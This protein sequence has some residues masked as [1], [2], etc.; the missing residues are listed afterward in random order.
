MVATDQCS[1]LAKPISRYSYIKAV[2]LMWHKVHPNP[3]T[4]L[5]A[6]TNPNPD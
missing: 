3:K 2:S 6:K 4:N 1:I 5:K